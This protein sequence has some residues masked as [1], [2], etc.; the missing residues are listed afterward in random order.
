MLKDNKEPSLTL[1]YTQAP[2]LPADW[3]YFQLRLILNNYVQNVQQQP[4]VN[5][6][7]EHKDKSFTDKLNNRISSSQRIRLCV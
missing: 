2:V 6:S 5:M 7:G 3:P 1:C 4:A